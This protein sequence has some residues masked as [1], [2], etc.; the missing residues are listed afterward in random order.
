MASEAAVLVI[1]A[2]MVSYLIVIHPC[3]YDTF[4]K[5]TGRTR[6]I[7]KTEAFIFFT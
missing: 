7:H 6:D 2:V 3:I 4:S 5:D 1:M